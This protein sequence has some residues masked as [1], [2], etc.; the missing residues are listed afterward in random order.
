MALTK[1]T[2]SLTDLDG[3]ITIDNITIDGTTM[4]L[5]SADLT[6]DVAGAIILDA[7]DNGNVSLK[8][9]GTRYGYFE[10]SNDNMLIQST[11]SDGDIIFKGSDG[12][13]TI[14]ALT[15]DMSNS[16]D[17]VFNRQI[18][19]KEAL[20]INK[21]DGNTVGY[22]FQS[23]DDLVLR[24][25]QSSGNITFNTNAS[26]RVRIDSSGNFGIGTTSPGYLVHINTSSNGTNFQYQTGGTAAYMA[27]TNT[28]GTSYIGTVNTNWEFYVGGS[29]KFEIT[30]SGGSSVS[31]EKF[32][33]NIE[34]ISYGLDTVKALKPRNFKWK[35]SQENGI[36]FIAQEVQPLISE[37]INVPTETSV[38]NLE[39]GMSMNYSA[40]T[41][42]LTKAIQE[43]SAKVEELESKI[44]E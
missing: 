13:S 9:G 8:D 21:A 5:S 10:K 41:A 35:D 1:V 7:D 14:T 44:N 22:I 20:Y 42:V 27:F 43:L 3:G 30:S 28:G 19:L 37:I 4:T 6:I 18:T 11:I 33:E 26:E 36:G 39:T 24:N 32:K 31:D 34:D 40:L 25:F 2:S 16:G 17:A 23:G 38:D 29:K 12:G 15:L